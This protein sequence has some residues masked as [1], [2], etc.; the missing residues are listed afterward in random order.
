MSGTAQVRAV[1]SD[2]GW[3]RVSCRPGRKARVRGGSGRVPPQAN[4]LGGNGV[5]RLLCASTRSPATSAIGTLLAGQCAI[6][7]AR[8]KEAVSTTGKSLLA[9][10]PEHARA[11]AAL[12]IANCQIELKD[13]AAAKTWR[14]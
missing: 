14:T 2:G 13:S 8:H 5:R 7:H 12:S 10:A 6:R 1:G 3:A 4:F 11:R 9:A